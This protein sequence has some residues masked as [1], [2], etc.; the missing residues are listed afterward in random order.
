MFDFLNK[1]NAVKAIFKCLLF[2]TTKSLQGHLQMFAFLNNKKCLLRPSSNVCFSQQK[3][4]LQGHLQ[5][6][7]FLNKKLIGAKRLFFIEN[8]IH[9]IPS[10]KALA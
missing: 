8:A 1:N 3:K 6:I 10:S 5:M 7:A 9:Y 2:S 4:S